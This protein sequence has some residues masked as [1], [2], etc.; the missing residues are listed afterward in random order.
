MLLSQTTCQSCLHCVAAGSGSS[1][2]WCRLRRLH[3]HPELARILFCHH[4][5]ARAPVLPPLVSVDQALISGDRQLDL[6]ASVEAA[7][8][9]DTPVRVL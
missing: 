9:Q 2:G 3:V 4:W 1:G 8:S 7:H 6:G 5:T